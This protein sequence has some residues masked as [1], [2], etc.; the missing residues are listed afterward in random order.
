MLPKEL[1]TKILHANQEQD[2]NMLP[3]ELHPMESGFLAPAEY[4]TLAQ[5]CLHNRSRSLLRAWRC[6]LQK[7]EER[8]AS[9]PSAATF[10]EEYP[11]ALRQILYRMERFAR[12]IQTTLCRFSTGRCT[13]VLVGCNCLPRRFFGKSERTKAAQFSSASIRE[14][15]LKAL[16]KNLIKAFCIAY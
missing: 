6:G 7:W 11:A 5:T 8:G 14:G 12:T 15:I 4:I 10:R 16:T 3:N 13:S 9:A 1:D 2:L